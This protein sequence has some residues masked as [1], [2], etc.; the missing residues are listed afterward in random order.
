MT[1]PDPGP[2]P[3]RVLYVE[4]NAIVRELTCELLVEGAAREIFA[5]ETAEEALK[6]FGTRPFD[7]VITDVSLPG[8]SGIEFVRRLQGIDASVP[9]IL[10]SGYPLDAEDWRLGPRVRALTKPFELPE[11]NAL[12]QSLCGAQAQ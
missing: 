5:V 3:L 1:G 11:L 6:S 12:I 10:V 2:S 7:L 8:M 9:I 4:D